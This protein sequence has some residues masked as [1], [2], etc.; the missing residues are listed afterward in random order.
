MPSWQNGPDWLPIGL[1]FILY[2]AYGLPYI[3]MGQI[4]Y[5]KLA[6]IRARKNGSTLLGY[7]NQSKLAYTAAKKLPIQR[8]NTAWQT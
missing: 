6:Y 8:Q 7:S 2:A 4:R 3:K 5:T 1:G